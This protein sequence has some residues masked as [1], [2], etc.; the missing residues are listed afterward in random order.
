M[1]P[2]DRKEFESIVIRERMNYN[3]IS[4][5]TLQWLL[6]LT[7]QQIKTT[8]RNISRQARITNIAVKQELKF[9]EDILV[10]ELKIVTT[11]DFW[12][13][14][15]EE[16]FIHPVYEESCPKCGHSREEQ[17]DSRVNEVSAMLGDGL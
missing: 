2:M 9:R 4:T 12:D 13:C 15:C 5:D 10:D 3:T 14:E 6:K 1:E 7:A 17:P 11:P 8:P 16:N